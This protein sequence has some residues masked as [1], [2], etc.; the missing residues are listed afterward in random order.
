MH[1]R[2]VA[3]VACEFGFLAGSI[4]RDAARRLVAAI[5]PATAEGIRADRFDD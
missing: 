2:R 1:G 4:G 3:V 5:R